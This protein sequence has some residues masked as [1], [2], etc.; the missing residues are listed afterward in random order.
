[1][2]HSPSLLQK[3]IR[4]QKT[5]LCLSLQWYTKMTNVFLLGRTQTRADGN[6]GTPHLLVAVLFM[7]PRIPL[8]FLTARVS[9]HGCWKFIQLWSTKHSLN[10][11]SDYSQSMEVESES[12]QNR[13][14][15][16]VGTELI[17]KV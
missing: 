12:W 6:D 11:L 4:L 5:A 14:R 13:K 3:A 17:R 8:A 10:C 16:T 9:V 15:R 2:L 7:Q 1:M